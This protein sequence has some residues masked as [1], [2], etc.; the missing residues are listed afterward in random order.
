M[1]PVPLRPA[2]ALPSPL[3]VCASPVV[4]GIVTFQPRKATLL[5]RCLPIGLSLIVAAEGAVRTQSGAWG[6]AGVCLPGCWY[7]PF[8][9]AR[10]WRLWL[11]QK[12]HLCAGVFSRCALSYM[13]TASRLESLKFNLI[14]IKWGC[15]GGPVTE[16]PTFGSGHY[17]GPVPD[18]PLQRG[19][20]S[21]CPC[22]PRHSHSSLA[23]FLLV[24][25]K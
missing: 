13:V 5:V 22:C 6:A 8:E 25:F 17:L 20:C 24:S 3:P 7:V 23:L 9:Q 16:A 1:L 12:Q 15:L 2:P 19:W 21:L 4:A 18:S 10:W 14:K 11:R